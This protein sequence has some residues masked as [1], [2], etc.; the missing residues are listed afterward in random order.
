MDCS[1][2]EAWARNNET[3]LE[4]CEKES[5]TI[6]GACIYRRTKKRRTRVDHGR[7]REFEQ[8][9]QSCQQRD[10]CWESIA[11]WLVAWLGAR[12]GAPRGLAWHNLS[13]IAGHVDEG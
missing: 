4:V 10:F 5:E 1:A 11:T 3:E 8:S 2:E 7:N 6:L 13:G 9:G 12:F